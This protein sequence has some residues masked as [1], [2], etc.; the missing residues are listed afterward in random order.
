MQFVH[1]PL[2]ALSASLLSYLPGGQS[3]HAV[4]PAS[5]YFPSAHSVQSFAEVT[6][7]AAEYFPAM[8]LVHTDAP[9]AD[10]FPGPQA[11]HSGDAVNPQVQ[12]GYKLGDAAAT[13]TCAP[14]GPTHVAGIGLSPGL[15]PPQ[16]VPAA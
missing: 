9:L 7:D 11:Q 13:L 5:E 3:V 4:A 12:V 10:H 14:E 6:T 1:A 15:F 8:Q 2:P 16:N